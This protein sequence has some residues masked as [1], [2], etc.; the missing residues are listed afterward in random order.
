MESKKSLVI[1]PTYNEK[2]NILKLIPAILELHTGIDIV[3]VDDNSP[4]GT[5]TIADQFH[6]Q[7]PNVQVLHREG[8]WGLGTA[9]V[10]G[11][12]FGLEH[13]YDYFI[14]MDA[15]FS[16]HPKYIPSLLAGAE[17]G[18]VVIGSRYIPGGGVRNWGWHRRVL[19]RTANLVARL[20]LGFPVKDCTSGFRCYRKSVLQQIKL[21]KLFSNGY[22]FLE[23]ILFCC[24]KN[25]CTFK[26]VPIVFVD[27]ELG[28]SKIAKNEII[29]AMMTLFRLRC[30]PNY[31]KK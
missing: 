19:S 4:D 1:L 23:E 7:Y 17:E 22:S 28:K 3:V 5:G 9:Y 29:K 8:K 11:F 14:T 20:L 18:D 30:N 16:H 10:A 25:G 12:K 13:D 21:D 2:E 31:F 6:Q 24:K 26:E 15:D 27:R